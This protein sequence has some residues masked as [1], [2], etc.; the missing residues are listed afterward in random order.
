MKAER[1]YKQWI[2]RLRRWYGKANGVIPRWALDNPKRERQH[3]NSKKNKKH[4]RKSTHSI[5][6]STILNP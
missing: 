3:E 5:F 1:S 2:K 6:P 4:T